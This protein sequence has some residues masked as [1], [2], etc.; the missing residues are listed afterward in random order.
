EVLAQGSTKASVRVQD[1]L[2]VDLRVIEPVCWGAALHYFTGSKAHNIRM[3]ERAIKRGYKLSEYG[4][5]DGAEVRI[6]GAGEDDIFEKLGLPYIPPVL[7][8]DL[9]EMEAAAQGNLPKL[10]DVGDIRG[11]L[12]MHT[13]WSDGRYSTEQMIIAAQKRG[14]EYVAI[15]DHSKSLSVA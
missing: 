10:I 15:T 6:A 9:G 2:Q 5:F 1:D 13:E 4:L 11:D 7:R 12:H 14:Y 3:R 8:E